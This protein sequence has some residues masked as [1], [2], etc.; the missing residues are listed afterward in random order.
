MAGLV[1]I[2]LLAAPFGV[3]AGLYVWAARRSPAGFGARD[4]AVLIVA[5]VLTILAAVIGESMAPEARGP[6]WPY[7][8]SALAGFAAMLALLGSGW[9]LRAR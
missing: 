9:A 3:L 6:I 1:A 4:R 2:L 7:V 5:A 8:Y